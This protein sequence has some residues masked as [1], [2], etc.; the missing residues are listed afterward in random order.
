MGGL[1]ST[2]WRAHVRRA[3]VE[4]TPLRVRAQWFADRLQGDQRAAHGSI[5][6]SR[7]L[8]IE[9]ELSPDVDARRL[10]EL[11]V[12]ASR[13]GRRKVLS[14]YRVAMHAA[15][16]PLGGRR[17]WF[18]CP[19]CRTRRQSLYVESDNYRWNC[20][21]CAGLAYASQSLPYH[22]RLAL[23]AEKLAKRTKV[24]WDPDDVLL[25]DR[26]HGMHRRTFKRRLTALKNVQAELDADF[27]R[28]L[29]RRFGDRVKKQLA[30]EFGS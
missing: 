11:R 26:P 19:Q 12:L 20:R 3:T 4:E 27:D 24:E 25:P 22:G 14:R 15:T 21:E 8:D 6:F 23:R 18:F 2:R 9:F 29:R 10:M 1:G 17:W 7:D 28:W 5:R 30:A 16:Q 13:A